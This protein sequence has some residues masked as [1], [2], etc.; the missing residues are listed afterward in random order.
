MLQ[1]ED[2]NL[3]LRVR[4]H[5]GRFAAIFGFPDAYP[6][7]RG[8]PGTSMHV[9]WA[10]LGG[11]VDPCF[12]IVMIDLPGAIDHH[13]PSADWNPPKIRNTQLPVVEPFDL[14]LF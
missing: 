3:L 12:R 10:R 1:L 6:Y 5:L 14:A 13:R 2:G 7:E 9:P 11:Q 4:F 8:G